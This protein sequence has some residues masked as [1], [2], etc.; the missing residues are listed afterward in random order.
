MTPRPL[1]SA[2]ATQRPSKLPK[3]PLPPPPFVCT[4]SL[5]PLPA[6]HQ[7]RCMHPHPP[8]PATSTWAK[9]RDN[10]LPTRLVKVEEA[11][12]WGCESTGTMPGR[13]LFLQF[14]LPQF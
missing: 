11:I 7:P 6:V 13:V 10:A 2:S 14:L 3:P 8:P 12:P 5:L 4:L 9:N 1:A